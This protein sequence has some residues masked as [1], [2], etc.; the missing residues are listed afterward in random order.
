MKIV[1]SKCQLTVWNK[2]KKVPRRK[3]VS[4]KH[5]TKKLRKHRLYRAVANACAKKSL[6][7]IIPCHSVINQNNETGGYFK[8]Q[9]S[10]KKKS[11]LIQELT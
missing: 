10:N 5:I 4:Y 6:S 2:I 11:L 7:T 9:N 3:T 8:E 1:E